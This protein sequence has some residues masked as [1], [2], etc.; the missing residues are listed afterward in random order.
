MLLIWI[1]APVRAVDEKK[2]IYIDRMS[3]FEAILKRV[4]QEEGVPAI[5]LETPERVDLRISQSFRFRTLS[6]WK[7]HYAA[8]GRRD[9]SVLELWNP[10]NKAAAVSYPFRMPQDSHT[11]RRVAREFMRLVK[12]HLAQLQPGP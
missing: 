11:Q 3:G 12:R 8:T 6:Q 4:A 2:R 9:D 7:A 10:A 1:A 5:F